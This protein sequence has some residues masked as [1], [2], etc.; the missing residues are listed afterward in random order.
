LQV[1]AHVLVSNIFACPVT[2]PAYSAGL[3]TSR[4]AGIAVFDVSEDGFC[5]C[6]LRNG[7]TSIGPIN[8]QFSFREIPTVLLTKELVVVADSKGLAFALIVLPS[9]LMD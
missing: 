2:L 1:N 5:F 9:E 8:D 3:R 7:Y 4:P 6:I